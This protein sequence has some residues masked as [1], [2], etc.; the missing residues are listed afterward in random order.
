MNFKVSVMKKYPKYYYSQSTYYT[1][2]ISVSINDY[3]YTTTYYYNQMYDIHYKIYNTTTL[4][5]HRICNVSIN[6]NPLVGTTLCE[7]D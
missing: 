6:D 7:D 2:L 5:D 1:L 4:D 3:K